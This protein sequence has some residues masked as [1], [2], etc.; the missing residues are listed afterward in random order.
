MQSTI[1]LR[2]AL[3]SALILGA[4]FGGSTAAQAQ[5]PSASTLRMAPSIKHLVAT[6]TP[7]IHGPHRIGSRLSLSVKSWKPKAVHFHYSW[8]RDGHAILT[9]THSTYTVR[10][11]DAGRRI[12]VSIVGTK[13]HYESVAR[14]SRSIL[15]DAAPVITTPVPVP[16]PVP[17]PAPAPAPAPVPAPPTSSPAPTPQPTAGQCDPNYSGACVPIA[18]DVDCAGGSGNGPAYVKGPVQVI[19]KDIYGLDADGDGVGCE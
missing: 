3:A 2:A 17:A 12:S 13:A 6:S 4:V 14:T 15:I 18:S 11:G 8:K 16:V 5:S 7:V 9:A 10:A 19:G 1:S